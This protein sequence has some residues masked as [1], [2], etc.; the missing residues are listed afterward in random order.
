MQPAGT[1]EC[2]GK[3]DYFDQFYDVMH[4][5]SW[6]HGTTPDDNKK[7]QKLQSPGTKPT[8]Q[9][10][11]KTRGDISKIQTEEE[12]EEEK[13]DQFETFGQVVKGHKV[14]DEKLRRRS[15]VRRQSEDTVTF[16]SV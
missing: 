6:E 12:G 9:E 5:N 2:G 15:S 14:V 16:G 13:G 11:D 7:F 3:K 10:D 8:V 1:I 4:D